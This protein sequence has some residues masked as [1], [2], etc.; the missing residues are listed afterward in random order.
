MFLDLPPAASQRQQHRNDRSRDAFLMEFPALTA[1]Q[2][3]SKCWKRP[4]P[5]E[6]AGDRAE[7]FAV[8]QMKLSLY[9]ALSS[10]T[11]AG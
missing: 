10:T 5:A 11:W 7:P 2:I 8:E 9:P 4:S 3:A 6:L 1:D